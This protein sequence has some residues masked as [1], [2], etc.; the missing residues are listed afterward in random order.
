MNP[1]A[2]AVLVFALAV[3]PAAALAQTYPSKPIRFVVPFPPGGG[4]DVTVRTVAQKMGE[5]LG[6]QIIV[7]N[8][9]GASGIIGAEFVAKSAPDGYTIMGT[10]SGHT[11]LPHLQKVPWDPIKDFTPIT[12]LV[13]YQLLL[14]VH[15]SV[16]ANSLQ[17]LIALA[18]AKPG[19]L[20]YGT[21]G[22]G[23]PPHLAME[24]LKSTAG[25]DI[26]HVPYKGNALV[27]AALMSGEIQ[28]SFDTMIGPLRGVRAGRLRGLA[29]SGK[30]RSIIAPEIPTVAEAG[31][32]GYEFEGWTGVFGPAGM[33]REIVDRLNSEIAKALAIPDIKERLIAAGYEPSGEPADK[34]A[35]LV[36][37]DLA[38]MGKIV[39]GGGIQPN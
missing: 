32:K 10:T 6:Q 26:V 21:G 23:T 35:A 24:L 34:F 3:L 5:S 36:S 28:A 22:A 9:A 33:P 39:K 27:T 18:K 20:N 1:I 7:D 38:K 12:A 4:V 17:E 37:A 11:I 8:R 13:T 31:L 19:V 2:R 14:S 29:V 25:V 16:P 15:P 30:R